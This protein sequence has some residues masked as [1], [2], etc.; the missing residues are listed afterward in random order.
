MYHSI[1]YHS[2]TVSVSAVRRRTSS[3]Y[4]SFWSPQCVAGPIIT[5]SI[6][7]ISAE[8]CRITE[9]R[10]TNRDKTRITKPQQSHCIAVVPTSVF[11]GSQLFST[12]L[13][14]WLSLLQCNFLF[15]SGNISRQTKKTDIIVD[16]RS[17]LSPSKRTTDQVTQYRSSTSNAPFYQV[18]LPQ[19]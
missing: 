14:D 1:S 19:K 18:R 12:L 2:I 13:I 8:R 11:I 6:D 4:H 17:E 10:L 9:Y 5:T 16:I 7:S 15:A 3:Q